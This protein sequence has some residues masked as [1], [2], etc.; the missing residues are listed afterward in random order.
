MKALVFFFCLFTT[1]LLLQSTAR[2][3]GDGVF[4]LMLET[5]HWQTFSGHYT[6]QFQFE[7]TDHQ[8]LDVTVYGW[9]KK[10][11]VAWGQASPKSR[12]GFM[13]LE[14]HDVRGNLWTGSVYRCDSS[15]HLSVSDGEREFVLD[16]INMVIPPHS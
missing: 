7:E 9:D 3:G 16:L 13:S 2:A 11:P 5:G 14:L 4:P 1:G 6:V 12:D 10:T 15:V 8:K